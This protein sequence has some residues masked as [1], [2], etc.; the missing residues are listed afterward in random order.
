MEAP[1]VRLAAKALTTGFTSAWTWEANEL[2]VLR[3]LTLA[4]VRVW[5]A[6]PV[7]QVTFGWLTGVMLAALPLAAF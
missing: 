4:V 6:I 1:S 3:S 2:M 7:S 5:L